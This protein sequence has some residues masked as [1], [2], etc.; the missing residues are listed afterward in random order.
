MNIFKTYT[1]A[2]SRTKGSAD[3][4]FLS[5]DVFSANKALLKSCREYISS[6]ER[7]KVTSTHISVSPS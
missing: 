6:I 1:A 3:R 5:A 4:N 7:E 2:E